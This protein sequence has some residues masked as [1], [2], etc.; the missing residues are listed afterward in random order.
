T[1]QQRA[2]RNGRVGA[3]GSEDN[4]AG[5]FVKARA[6]NG[7]V[8]SFAATAGHSAFDS[9]IPTAR[10]RQTAAQT[11]GRRARE[12]EG[13]VTSGRIQKNGDGELGNSVVGIKRE[14]RRAGAFL[15]SLDERIKQISIG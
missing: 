4:T 3:H 13:N 9:A 7:T 12:G 11:A 15:G 14:R 5:L 1:D 2:A 8:P 10:T 6:L